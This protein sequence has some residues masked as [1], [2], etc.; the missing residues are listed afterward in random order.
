MTSRERGLLAGLLCVALLARVAA[1]GLTQQ[2][3]ARDTDNY[4][5]LAQ[6]LWE[7]GV[8]GF[9]GRPTAFRPPLYPWLLAPLAAWPGSERVLIGGLHALL[10]AGSVW[11]TWHLARRWQLGRGGWCA[12]LWVACD[13]LLVYQSTQLMTETLATFFVLAGLAAVDWACA[14]PTARSALF[15]GCLAGL[16]GLCRPT[17]YPW[18]ASLAL[19]WLVRREMRLRRLCTFAF[20]AVLVVAPWAVRNTLVFGRPIL[21]TTHGGYTL[22]L[23]HNPDYYGYLKRGWLQSEPWASTA[24][25][26]RLRVTLGSVHTPADEL[27]IDDAQR[28]QALAA[29]RADPTGCALAIVAHAKDFWSP[30]PHPRSATEGPAATTLRWAIAFGYTALYG[31][32]VLGFVRNRTLRKQSGW[33][34][35]ALLALTLA[36]VHA[37]YFSNQRMRAPLIPWLA[38]TAAAALPQRQVPRD[39]AS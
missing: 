1:V 36:L 12:A 11:L 23:A 32:A 15:V 4:W 35:G 37:V 38:L 10:G 7:D 2:A 5:Q 18:A 14:R 9:D 20:G 6:A 39:S 26:E 19:P 22:L 13:P 33:Q 25:D 17:F 21:T 8:F 3:F 34:A 31:L 29:M 27:L 16:A 24:L 30:L 28:A